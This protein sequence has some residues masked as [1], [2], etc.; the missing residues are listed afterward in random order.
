[1]TSEE[2]DIPIQ[3]RFPQSFDTMS[4]SELE[5]YILALK[6]EIQK[7]E[8]LIEKKKKAE[9]AAHSAFKI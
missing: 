2:N 1:M 3:N 4:V 8:G 6:T 7:A 5:D 9:T